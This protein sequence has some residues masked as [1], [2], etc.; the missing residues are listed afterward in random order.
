MHVANIMQQML[1]CAVSRDKSILLLF[2]PIFLSGNSFD[3]LYAQYVAQ[4]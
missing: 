2:L 3:L 1:V 4:S